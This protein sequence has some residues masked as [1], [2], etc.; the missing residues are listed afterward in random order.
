MRRRYRELFLTAAALSAG[1]AVAHHSPVMFD[2]TQ[3][4]TMTGTVREFQWTNPH[5]YIQ[6][7][8]KNDQGQDEEWSLEMGASVYLYNLGWRP[9]SVKAGDTLTVT[10]A[11][12]RKGGNGGLLLKAATAD[13]KQIGRT[14]SGTSGVTPSATLGATP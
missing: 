11:P 1:T 5:S 2:P 9:S 4:R 13:G 8:V 12:L 7:V 10:I 6:L 14:P 3:P